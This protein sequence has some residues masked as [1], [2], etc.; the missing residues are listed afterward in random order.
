LLVLGLVLSL[1]PRAAADKADW[2]VLRG[3]ARAAAPVRYDPAAW[4]A[5]PA[6]YLDDTPAC[7]LYSGTTHR[8]EA[9][10]TVEATTQELIRLNGRKGIDQLG[11]YHTIT[12]SPS[13]E[14]VTLHE[15]RV[16]KARGGVEPV[17]PRHVHLRD[18]NTDHQIYELSKQLVIS[19]PGLEVGDV[20]EVHWT[21]RGKHPEFRGQFFNRYSFGNEKYPVARDEWTVR[22]PKGRAL[23][24]AGVNADVPLQVTDEGD[25]R[26]YHWS[27]ANRPVPP[28]GDRLSPLDER[29]PQV[30]C[31]TFASWDDVYRWERNLIIDR[32]ACPADVR[33]V[34][35][36]V[37]RGLADPAAKAKAL[38]QWVRRRVRYVSRGEKHDYTPSPPAEVLAYRYGDCKDTAHLLTVMLRQ[39]GIQAGV[40][41]LGARG[42]GQVIESLP[43]PWS[44]H[45]LVLATIDGREHWIDTTANQI[46]WDVLPRDDRDRGCYVTDE[47][48]LRVTR[49]PPLAP[50]ENATVQTVHVAVGTDGAL[51][52]ERAVTYHGLAAWLKRDDY[53]DTP[54]GE[55][56]RLAAAELVDAYPKA[57]LN[58]LAFD[59]S[60]DD[61]DRPLAVR[62]TFSV[63]DHFRG[64][65]GQ[66]GSLSDNLLWNQ[67]LAITLN[68]ERKAAL[69]LGEPF[70]SVCRYVVQLPPAL[71]FEEVPSAQKV[72]SPWGSFRLDVTQSPDAPHR[73]ELAFHTRLTKSTVEPSEFELFR[74][75]QD[76]IQAVY[77]ARLKLKPTNAPADAPLLEKALAAAPGDATTAATLAELYIAQKKPDAARRVLEKARRAAPAERKL[78]EL[79]LAAAS[80]LDEEEDLY[81]EMVERFTDEPRYRLDLALNL[82]EQKRLDDARKELE[83]LT[84]HADA[85]V[86]GP[87]LVALAHCCLEE[88]EPKAA[89]RHLTA[90][91]EAH[92][93]GF[94]ADAWLLLGAVHEELGE[95]GP[96]LEAY[97]KALEKEPAAADVLA[98]LTRATVAAGKRD[99]ALG[100]L[101]RL[102]IAA[103]DDAEG[104]AHAADGY[105]RLG[106]F[107]DA[108]ELAARAKGEDGKL[109]DSALAPLGLALAHRGEFAQA[110]KTL[111][112]VEPDADVLTARI[113]TR[114]ALGDLGGAVQ[115]ADKERGLEEPT[116]ELRAAV[117]E[118]QALAGR[119]RELRR[120]VGQGEAPRPALERFVCAE[121]LHNR[122]EWP[123]RVEALLAEALSGEVRPGPAFGLRAVLHLEHGRLTKALADAE[124]AVALAPDDYRGY[125]ARGR[126]R[127]ERGVNGALADLE[128]AVELS[129]RRDAAALHALAAALAQ[130]GRKPEAVQAQREAAKLRPEDKELQE[131]LREYESNETG[132]GGAQGRR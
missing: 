36:E 19:F 119:L 86:R 82:V 88:A 96:A 76:S 8:L 124:Q 2:P 87:A 111:S 43:S 74:T 122:S 64:E 123:G 83:P 115:D 107:D 9:D 85:A 127:F 132:V 129:R 60:L 103:G 117:A 130:T 92:A 47:R 114:I 59:E 84:K 45:A 38:A 51:R 25:E 53:A 50:E 17:S 26:V 97:R 70:A 29:L 121:H 54:Q 41:S 20:I 118:A 90:A 80:D 65:K 100:Y 94:D 33:K 71:R 98:A 101:R 48:G 109:P 99:E 46:G 31:S 34:V 30:A 79:S 120:A 14:T 89:L 93:D 91:R 16:H 21:T 110:L 7:Y 69:D 4:K 63:P 62:M 57:K 105:A 102:V 32:S 78:W 125:L 11:E 77:Q 73:L 42:D 44:T 75:F 37:T 112:L 22:V 95:R 58:D 40:V 72:T 52:G 67:L 56:R 66:V 23:R 116:P 15:A 10:G 18:V 28:Q 113:R 24:Y 108:Y 12:F 27:M 128:K 55:R 39:A 104:L 106:R 81:R 68:P 5:V 49:T 35:E 126:V 13:Y 131:Q 1:T 3:P 61:Y 6:E